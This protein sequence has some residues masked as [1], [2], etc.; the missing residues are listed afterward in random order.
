MRSQIL[1][2]LFSLTLLVNCKSVQQAVGGTI[3]N[4][5]FQ[6][7]GSTLDSEVF[8]LIGMLLLHQE[9]ENRWPHSVDE[10]GNTFGADSVKLYLKNFR[11]LELSELQDTL[12]TNFELQADSSNVIT[13]KLKFKDL[14]DSTFMSLNLVLSSGA[15]MKGYSFIKLGESELTNWGN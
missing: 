12:Y 11:T 7:I 1:A 13:G 15:E 6:P 3:A 10:L 14:T 4:A 5:M 8:E 2:V 9:Q